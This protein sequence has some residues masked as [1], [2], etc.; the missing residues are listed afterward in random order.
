MKGTT[1]CSDGAEPLKRRKSSVP[2]PI[3]I[4][5]PVCRAACEA[6]CCP[7]GT[8][9]TERVRVWREGQ[10]KADV[11]AAREALREPGSKTLE[12]LKKDLKD[13]G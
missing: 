9:H 3:D 6:K 8:H 5:C 12:Q 13:N 10:D 2:S 4:E 7:S 11:R 1:R